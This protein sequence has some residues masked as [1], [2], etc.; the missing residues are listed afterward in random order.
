MCVSHK[1]ILDKKD[2]EQRGKPAS[3][4]SDRTL[5]RCQERAAKQKKKRA[6]CNWSHCVFKST[7]FEKAHLDLET[8]TFFGNIHLRECFSFVS[9]RNEP[10]VS[11]ATVVDRASLC[12]EVLVEWCLKQTGKTG[13][14]HKMAEIDESN[15]GKRKYNVGRLIEGQWVSGGLCRE[16]RSCFMVPVEKRDGETLLKVIEE[17]IEPGTTII[18][19]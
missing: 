1:L 4:D 13:G 5:W 14:H 12:R 3:L 17:R 8:V 6:E 10:R 7:F 18:S 15:S 9:A 11:D 19:D 2:R 16:T